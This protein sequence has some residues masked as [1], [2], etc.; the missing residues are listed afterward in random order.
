MEAPYGYSL[1]REAV[2]NLLQSSGRERRRLLAVFAGLGRHPFSLG[3]FQVVGA[4]GRTWQLLD[5][6]EFVGTFWSDHAARNV[7]ILHL[8]R[9]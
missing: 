9:A 5:T 6:G 8:E 3:D 1:D 7:R 4:D 2:E